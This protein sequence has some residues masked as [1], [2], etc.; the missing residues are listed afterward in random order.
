MYHC[1]KYR[2]KVVHQNLI[3]SFPNKTKEEISAI[4]RKFYRHLCDYFF[5]T[6]KILSMSKSE[7]KRRIEIKNPDELDKYFQN[8]QSIFL[9]L[10]HYANWEWLAFSWSVAHP[11]QKNYKLYPAYFRP[12]NKLVEKIIL[13]LREKANSVL[14]EKR[15]M[16]RSVLKMNQEDIHGIFIFLADQRPHRTSVQHWMPF[17]NQDTPTIIGPEKLAK[18]LRMPLFYYR[19]KK[20]RRGYFSAELV[21][22]AENPEEFSDF[23]ITEMYMRELEKQINEE[24]AY[25]LWTHKRWKF[26]HKNFEN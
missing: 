6:I 23:E 12:T 17:L 24:P 15:N 18:K 1:I 16:L 5:E 19:I 26:K 25:W 10:S 14:I 9:Y 21:K 8:K 3:N 2:K 4:E 7:I 13:H 22:L 20:L 11:E